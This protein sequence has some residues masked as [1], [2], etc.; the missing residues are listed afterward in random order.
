LPQ[1]SGP[2][3]GRYGVPIWVGGEADS[4]AGADLWDNLATFNEDGPN[5]PQYSEE[6]RKSFGVLRPVPVPAGPFEFATTQSL[7][8]WPTIVWDVN[9]YY[10]DL[11]VHPRA[12][13]SELREA[14]QRK[15]GWRS[16]R[17][18]Y[19]LHQLLDPHIRAAYDSCRAGD[20]F[21]DEYVARW[22]HDELIN[23][24]IKNEGRLL[25]LDE[26]IA[27]GEEE[28]DMGQYLNKPYDLLGAMMAEKDGP[29]EEEP[30]DELR[31]SW[32]WG[33]YD[34]GALWHD[35]D[36]LRT[37]QAALLTVRVA[38][39]QRLC[40]GLLTSA[41]PFPVRL[42]QIGLRTGAF[43]RE[44]ELPTPAHALTCLISLVEPF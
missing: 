1:G 3:Y 2:A 18:T 13:R 32:K 17:L 34:W 28:L 33:Y 43:L 21:F 44:N 12:K 20:T 23:D 19:V 14:Y 24:S 39:P 26:R 4:G 30:D 22:F 37:W 25:T 5:A 16:E 11:G 9:L 41:D 15:E 6:E 31:V 38:K 29:R 36:L 40:V 7:E 27:K 8:L 10:S 35:I 42:V